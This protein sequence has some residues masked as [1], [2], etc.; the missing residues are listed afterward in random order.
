M[1]NEC[2]VCGHINRV[3]ASVCEMCDARLGV[4]EEHAAADEGAGAE[5]FDA[6]DAPGAE[7]REGA[8]PTDIPL[9]Q[10]KGAGDVIGPTL[11]VYK[12]NFPLVGLLVLVAALPLVALQLATYYS[13][14][15][16]ASTPREIRHSDFSIV[17]L[18]MGA[19]LFSFLLTA[20]ANAL[21]TGALVYAVVEL[22]RTGAARAGD[23][24]RW[25]LKKLPKVFVIS[26]LYTV[27]TFCGYLLLIVP[28]VILSLMF[29]V[30]VV[31]AA[32]ENRGVVGSFERSKHLTDGYKG[33]IF[34][35]YFLWGLAVAVVGFL[36][37]I[38]FA[39][40]G[41]QPSAVALVL[42]SLIQEVLQSTTIVLTVFIF[43][44]LLNEH[45]HGFDTHTFTP[46]PADAA[47]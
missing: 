37:G 33:L 38:S 15:S 40:G 32:A 39:A 7:A 23:C 3:S 10:F 26:L 24:L 22:Q 42:Q 21:L 25:G 2:A 8:L 45:R 43:L 29:A 36:V 18:S 1:Y 14:A 35:T 12:K 20:L 16:W 47:R 19:G 34:L 41:A 30:A 6:A 9:P 46:A 11:D 13:L 17:A 44:G 28:G 31:A 5:R 27:M 4:T